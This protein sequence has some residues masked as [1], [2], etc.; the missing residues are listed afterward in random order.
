PTK[1]GQTRSMLQSPPNTLLDVFG[2]CRPNNRS[3]FVQPSLTILNCLLPLQQWHL[4]CQIW[5]G[6][7]ALS[8]D[9]QNS[10]RAEQKMVWMAFLTTTQG[11]TRFTPFSPNSFVLLH[12]LHHK[13][14]QERGNVVQC[15]VVIFYTNSSRRERSRLVTH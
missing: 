1:D 2:S 8:E 14:C 15:L 3:G 6:D 13:P 11:S 9:R 12:I 4:Y 10:W 7:C 5:Q